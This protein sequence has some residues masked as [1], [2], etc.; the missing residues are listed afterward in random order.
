MKYI[1]LLIALAS[2]LCFN[3]R[4]TKQSYDAYVMAVQWANGYC[5]AQ[6]CGG[7]D[8]KVIKNTMTIHGLWPSLKSGKRLNVC[9]SGVKIKEDSSALFNDMRTYWPSFAKANTEFWGH[10]YNK[11][12]Y[13]MVEE[14][15]WKGYEQYFRYT[16]DLHIKTYKNL[17]LKAF[18]GYSGKNTVKYEQLKEAI[19]RI[20]PNATIN[21]KCTSGYI[22]ELYFYLEKDMSPCPTCKFS[23]A[24]KSGTLVFK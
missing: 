1:L 6:K 8:S 5:T 19:R 9:T 4:S 23:N 21:M 17:F 20:I 2:T 18:P 11:H 14:K 16:L 22:T 12:G 13:C 3:L 10:E 7:K 15:G 24:C